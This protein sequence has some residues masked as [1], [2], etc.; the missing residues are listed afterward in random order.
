MKN[1]YL[2][3]VGR[4]ILIWITL[5]FAENLQAQDSLYAH[6]KTYNSFKA[7][8]IEDN[9]FFVEEA[10]NQQKGIVQFISTCYFTKIRQGNMAYSFTHELPLKGVKHQFSYTLNYFMFPSLLPNGHG[11][12]DV[13][14]NYRYEL[15]GKNNWALV[16]PRLS[17]II[18]TGDVSK[19]LG[20]GAWG[21]QVNL[22]VSKMLSNKLVTHYNAGFT[23]L[24][25]A[26]YSLAEPSAQDDFRQKDLTHFHAGASIIW[27]AND[28]I[29][30]MLEYMSS[31]NDQF[32]DAGQVNNQHQLLVNPGIRY[33]FKAG[34][35]Q[36]VPGISLPI[37]WQEDQATTG[38]FLYLSIEPDFNLGGN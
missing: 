19:G 18:P 29:N 15:A 16:T 23:F 27:L 7:P 9:S 6:K 10:F 21:T 28:R 2:W 1:T 3:H 25:N 35:S 17:L 20:S 30:G 8:L 31:F 4:P 38:L 37:T 11:L 36:I 34:Q 26:H 14:V 32:D 5:L 33:A 12:G 22:P 24:K 13:M